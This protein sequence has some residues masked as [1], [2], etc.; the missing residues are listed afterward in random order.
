MRV[1]LLAAATLAA[2]AGC[3]TVRSAPPR[4]AAPWP[5]PLP[6]SRGSVALVVAGGARIDNLGRDL[7]PILPLWREAIER[8]YRESGQFSSVTPG[9]GSADLH[10]DVE[11]RAEVSQPQA[12]ALVSAMT[13]FLIPTVATTEITLDTRVRNAAGEPIG[14]SQLRGE[15]QTWSQVLLLPVSPF[16]QQKDVTPPIVYDLARTS[17]DDLRRGGA[18]G[19]QLR[20]TDE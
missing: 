10:V 17:I 8:A 18:F 11:V 20:P 4:V 9:L 19:E 15:S 6:A 14:T 12:L 13:L 16:F 7:G 3:V 2:V 1:R 5:P